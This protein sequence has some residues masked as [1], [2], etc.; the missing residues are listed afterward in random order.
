MNWM[1]QNT[2]LKL[3]VQ[4]AEFFNL[5]T[6]ECRL[7]REIDRPDIK[8]Y[9]TIHQQVNESLEAS[10]SSS[11]KRDITATILIGLL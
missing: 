2:Y 9:P 7:Q 10:L 8:F 4:L 5:W 1:A 6:S 3:S 11:V